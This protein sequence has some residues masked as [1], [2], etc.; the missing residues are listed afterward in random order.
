MA[1]ESKSEGVDFN[2][3]GTIDFVI[4]GSVKH[5][6]RPKLREFRHWAE[7]L[8]ELAR[9]AQKEAVRLQDALAELTKLDEST[10][11]G[12]EKAA[13]EAEVARIEAELEEANLKR[14]EYTVPWIAGVVKQFAN[15]D[16]PEDPEDWPAWLVLDLSIP[17]KVLAHWKAV[18]L[19]PGKAG[20]N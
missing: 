4:D 2:P 6:R 11:E 3:D 18:P 7:Q 19:A 8:R 5:L 13:E 1:R 20:T 12:E 14:Q 15:A 10:A 9:A 16:M 17:A